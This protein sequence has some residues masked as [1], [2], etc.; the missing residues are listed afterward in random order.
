MSRHHRHSSSSSS[1]SPAPESSG[2]SVASSES[3]VHHVSRKQKRRNARRRRRER[4]REGSTSTALVVAGAGSVSVD[5]GPKKSWLQT[6]E[7]VLIRIERGARELRSVT[8][9]AVSAVEFAQGKA[10]EGGDAAS[11]L[12]NRA[13]RLHKTGLMLA[14][15]VFGY[16]FFGLRTAFASSERTAE[17]RDQLH[18]ENAA[19]FTR[20]S[21]EQ[22]GAFL[23]VGQLLSAR[24]DLL[25]QIWVRELAALQDAAPIIPDAE[26]RAALQA[27]LGAPPE[28][29]FAEFDYA[30]I[31]AAS[32]GQ[33]HRA[34][35]SDGIPVAVKLQRPGIAARIEDD[36]ALLDLTIEALRGSLPPIDLNTVIG[37]IRNHIRAEVD[38]KREA[39]LTARA[40]HFFE[41]IP[42]I[43]VPE[44]VAA[45]CSA[46]VLTTRFIQGRKISIV[47]DELSEKRDAGDKDAQAQLSELLG[48]LLQSYLRQM[49]ELGM[50]QADP[51]PGNLMVTSAGELAILDFG[52][53]A[54]L[55]DEIRNAYLALLGSFFAQDKV[56]LAKAFMDLGFRTQS[57][58]P[59]T[60]I[61]FMDAL[62]GE[63][64]QALAS[65]QVSWPDRDAIAARAKGLGKSLEADPVVGLP[66][67]F[68]MIG[69]V[70]ATIGG[71]FSHY[72]P[73]LDVT[74]HVLPV[75][76]AALEAPAA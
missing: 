50:F 34:M 45:L 67:H 39:E 23:K 71:L 27:S 20:T 25:P 6:L 10:G 70:L 26:A 43:M 14:Q 56:R 17:L 5:R 74:V 2:P 73:D 55:S 76:A 64:A 68:V 48:R 57:G 49:L 22:G 9:T 69:R 31:A 47:L 28:E 7:D 32:I 63:L 37:E 58:K 65:G 54:E 59:D 11:T 1:T 16:R 33:V 52:C 62:L 51:H 38:Y 18:A 13:T 61:G 15:L 75:L 53:A 8:N 35:T 60:L 4:S 44:P 3:D 29:R 30:P 72:R 12:R 46:E 42:G 36:L 41:N 66:G 19:R 40:A 24:A 21:A